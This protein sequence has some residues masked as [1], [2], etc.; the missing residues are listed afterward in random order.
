M[1][2]RSVILACSGPCLRDVDVKGAGLPIAAISTAIRC[3]TRPEF[4]I[5]I[6]RPNPHY[7]PDRGALYLNDPSIKKIT[8]ERL[9]QK[10]PAY[11]NLHFVPYNSNG[12]D[13]GRSFMDGKAKL[14]RTCHRS[15]LFAVQWLIRQGFTKLIFAGVNLNSDP[16]DPYAYDATMAENI[17]REANHQHLKELEYLRQWTPLAAMNGI[18]FLSWSP[19]SPINEFMPLFDQKEA[20]CTP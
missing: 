3:F 4:W 9:R 6:D 10:M 1:T 2:Q 14:L 5:F 12:E 19:G 20:T 11:P 15:S 17:A 8:Q 13:E 7:G 18:T 16:T